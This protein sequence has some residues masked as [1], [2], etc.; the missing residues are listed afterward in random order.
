[1]AR[2][3]WLALLSL[4]GICALAAL[5]VSRA[6]PAQ[7]QDA[8]VNEEIGIAANALAKGRQARCRSNS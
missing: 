8:F 3:V 1:M 7:Q 5:K 2:P 6:E 4:I